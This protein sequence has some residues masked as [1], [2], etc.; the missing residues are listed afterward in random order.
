MTFNRFVR[1]LHDSSTISNRDTELSWEKR[2]IMTLLQISSDQKN[3]HCQ[4]TN[5]LGLTLDIVI[6]FTIVFVVKIIAV[7]I[8]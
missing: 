2:S 4:H 1:T 3:L 5:Y 7:G 8:R 6:V